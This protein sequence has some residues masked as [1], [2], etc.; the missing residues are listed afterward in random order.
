MDIEM[1]DEPEI[2]PFD[3]L[4]DDLPYDPNHPNWNPTPKALSSLIYL[5]AV[6]VIQS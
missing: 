4:V 2:E 3:H 1:F 5:R 6:Y